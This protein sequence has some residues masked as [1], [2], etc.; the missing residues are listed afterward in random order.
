MIRIIRIYIVYDRKD[1]QCFRIKDTCIKCIVCMCVSHKHK[2]AT[3]YGDIYFTLI[4]STLS[5][6]SKK[7][8]L[9][10]FH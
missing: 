9:S 7:I 6:R 3:Q 10:H 8:S 1:L 2:H 5:E 4:T